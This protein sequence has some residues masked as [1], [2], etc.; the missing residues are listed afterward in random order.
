[1]SLSLNNLINIIIYIYELEC[2][3]SVNAYNIRSSYQDASIYIS[4]LCI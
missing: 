3:V 1:M 2:N 4:L